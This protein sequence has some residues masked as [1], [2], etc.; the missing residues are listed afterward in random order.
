MEVICQKLDHFG[1]GIVYQNNK[2]TFVPNLLPSEKAEIRIIK[3]KKNYAEGKVIKLLTKSKDRITPQCPY[4]NCGCALKHLKYEKQIL[5]K[6]EKVKEIINKFTNVNVKINPIIKSEHIEFYRNKITLKTNKK[7]G[8]YENQTHDIIE[9]DACPLATTKINKIIKL[10]NKQ[11]LSNVKELIIK[12]FDDTML[13]IKGNLDI[14]PLK[15]IVDIIYIDDKLVY[16]NH[17]TKT[18]IGDFYFKVSKDSFFQINKYQTEKLYNKA[19]SYVEGDKEKTA[20]DLYCGTGTLALFLSN[21]FKKVIGIDINKEAIQCALENKKINRIKNVEF[22]NGDVSNT[23]DKLEADI[24][25]VDPPR[26][27]LTP[28]VINDIIRINPEKIIYISCDP[29]TLARDLKILNNKYDIQEITPVDMFPNTYHVE[30]VCILS[31]KS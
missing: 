29:V 19:L 30:C 17:Y 26:S 3:D 24:I 15:K 21:N 11:D 13:I 18:K 31:I 20:L 10:L 27:G 14:E 9:I 2:I 7:V 5:Y 16:G 12:D 23:I 25:F 28:K 4:Q 1:R 8:Y 6:E 22:I